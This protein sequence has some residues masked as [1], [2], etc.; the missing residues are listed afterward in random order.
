FTF[1]TSTT[2][3]STDLYH[4]RIDGGSALG[5]P[6]FL[7][8]SI[9]IGDVTQVLDVGATQNIVLVQNIIIAIAAD[10]NTI[11]TVPNTPVNSTQIW[12]SIFSNFGRPNLE[13]NGTW[14]A[15]DYVGSFQI[16]KYDSSTGGYVRT[17]GSLV[18]VSASLDGGFVPEPSTWAIM[19]LGFGA[20]G[21]A[22]RRRRSL[23]A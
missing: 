11:A 17:F 16:S 21:S 5:L 7:T 8:S 12:L 14:A 9:T 23:A 19:L 1:D 10:S 4:D 15:T 13:R 2:S 18:P 3:R 22:F 20:V 6:T